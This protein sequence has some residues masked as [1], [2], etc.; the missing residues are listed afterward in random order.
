MLPT[1]Y[2]FLTGLITTLAMDWT[3]RGVSTSRWRVGSMRD[4]NLHGV[5]MLIGFLIMLALL[6][7]SFALGMTDHA[8]LGVFT[9]LLMFACMV[10][11]NVIA[12][13]LSR[14]ARRPQG[15]SE[16]RQRRS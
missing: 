11:A 6:V 15:A 2:C 13:R 4:F 16:A 7:T 10:A 8:V 3:G 14:P 5:G 1:P 9:S 12:L